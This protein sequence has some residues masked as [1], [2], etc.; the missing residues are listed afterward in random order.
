MI[1]QSLTCAPYPTRRASQPL[2]HL[3]E[4]VDARDIRGSPDHLAT[5]FVSRKFVPVH[6]SQAVRSGRDRLP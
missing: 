5:A 1:S 4:H 3:P 2:P 6:C